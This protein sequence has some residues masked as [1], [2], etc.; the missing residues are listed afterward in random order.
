MPWGSAFI[1]KRSGGGGGKEPHKAKKHTACSQLG[2]C[3]LFERG[4]THGAAVQRP[5]TALQEAPRSLH[6]PNA[7]SCGTVEGTA[8]C[9]PDGCYVGTGSS[10]QPL[11]PLV[12]LQGRLHAHSLHLG[13]SHCFLR[14]N[15][16]GEALKQEEKSNGFPPCN[17]TSS[18]ASGSCCSSIG[19]PRPRAQ[20]YPKTGEKG[21]GNSWG[22]HCAGVAL[23]CLRDPGVQTSLYTM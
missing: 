2:L 8:F 12:V 5:H 13:V 20:R 10:E 7:C 14:P 15:A 4:P 6:A 21:G 3:F 11:H 16:D 9:L 19:L 23:T 18:S 22:Q 1:P 17:G